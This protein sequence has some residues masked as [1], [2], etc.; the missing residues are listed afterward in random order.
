MTPWEWFVVLGCVAVSGPLALL[1]GMVALHLRDG[2]IRLAAW[3]REH[4]R[5]PGVAM[6]RPLDFDEHGRTW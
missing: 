6:G 1:A 5:V 4:A 3:R 2:R